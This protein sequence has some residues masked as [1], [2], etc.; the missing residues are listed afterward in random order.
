[1]KDLEVV[2]E[3]SP[4]E[5]RLLRGDLTP[6]ELDVMADGYE[7]RADGDRDRLRRMVH[8][9]QT[10]LC[11]WKAILEYFGEEL[12]GEELGGEH[13]G[14]C[15]NCSKPHLDNTAPPPA[16]V[17]IRAPHR[18]AEVLSLSSMFGDR[19]PALVKLGDTLILPIFGS[20]KVR[21]ADDH[22]VIIELG[23]GEMREFRR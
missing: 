10:A 7:K 5:Y 3:D 6:E 9:A 1:M 4:G 11:R 14:H 23:D 8:Y 2:A 21:S 20:G 12:V 13:C 16:E 15:D 18:A 17:P 19:D 22:S